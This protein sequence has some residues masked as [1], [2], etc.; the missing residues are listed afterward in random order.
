MGLVPSGALATT[1]NAFPDLLWSVP[2]QWTLEEA[3]TVPSAYALVRY[4]KLFYTQIKI[5]KCTITYQ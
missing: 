1:V 4:L 3:I 5:I 2:E